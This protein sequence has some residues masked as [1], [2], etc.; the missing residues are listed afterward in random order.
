MGWVIRPSPS[1]G[2]VG[3]VP[4][5]GNRVLCENS[6]RTRLAVASQDTALRAVLAE[7]ERGGFLG[8]RPGAART[9]EALRLVH[10]VQGDGLAGDG[11]LPA[12]CAGYGTERAPTAGGA[13]VI[14]DTGD[15]VFTM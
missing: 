11:H 6:G 10:L 13:I 4:Q 1:R 14:V 5:I 8:V 9:V 12:Q 3:Q 2:V 15:S 7:L